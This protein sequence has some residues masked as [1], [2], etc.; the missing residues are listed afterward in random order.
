[1][2]RR[3]VV[4]TGMGCITPLGHSVEE[5]WRNI[6]AGASGASPTELFDARTFPSTFSA[7]V[8][9]FRLADYVSDAT[10]FVTRGGTRISPWRRPSRPGTRAG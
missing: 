8:K 1:M 10:P 2:S 6:L 7:Q 3:R 4:I 9:N 5:M